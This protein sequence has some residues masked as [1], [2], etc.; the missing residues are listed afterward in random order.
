MTT[1]RALLVLF[2]MI[3]VGLAVVLIRRQSARA[4]SR[5]QG[6]HQRKIELNQRLWI[7]QIELAKLRGP[8]AIRRRAR[9]LGFD[10]VSPSDDHSGHGGRLRSR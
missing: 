5:V 6:L 7:E 1:P 2:M 8:E 3:A 4:A 10:V 9:K